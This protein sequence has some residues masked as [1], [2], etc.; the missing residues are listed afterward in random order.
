MGNW[1]IIQYLTSFNGM[2]H[3]VKSGRATVVPVKA[4]RS[5]ELSRYSEE[6]ES[7]TEADVI[8]VPGNNS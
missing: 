7:A 8:K 1:F 3:E 5:L 4:T 2:T 6:A